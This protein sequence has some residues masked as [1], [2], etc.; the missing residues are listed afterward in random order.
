MMRDLVIENDI[1]FIAIPKLGCGLDRLQWGLVRNN[2]EFVFKDTDIKI[3][4]CHL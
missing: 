3:L 4:V 1:K 2:I